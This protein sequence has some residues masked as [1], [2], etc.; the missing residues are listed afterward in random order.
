MTVIYPQIK[1]CKISFGF[2]DF[3]E[4]EDS[5]REHGVKN[6]QMCQFD[7]E[8]EIFSAKKVSLKR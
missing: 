8:K 4:L 2:S 7:P 6:L 5:D 1:A 3:P